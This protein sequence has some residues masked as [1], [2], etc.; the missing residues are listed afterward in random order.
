MKWIRRDI[1]LKLSS[2]FTLLEVMTVIAI[3]GILAATSITM[4][5]KS[6]PRARKAARELMGDMQAT[7]IS[8]IKN[9]QDWAIVFHPATRTYYI[10]SDRG[11]DNVWSTII[12]SNTIEKTISLKCNCI[13]FY[14]L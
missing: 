2:G 5:D 9:N 13:F 12:G 6:E 3:M 1:F 14:K 10:C 8:A 11:A 4:M 7:R